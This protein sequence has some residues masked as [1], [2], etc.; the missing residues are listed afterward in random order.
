MQFCYMSK[1]DCINCVSDNNGINL[2]HFL[3]EKSHLHHYQAFT[4][5]CVS[6]SCNSL[7][8]LCIAFQISIPQPSHH[9]TVREEEQYVFIDSV[10]K[11]SDLDT[12]YHHLSMHN[13]GWFFPPSFVD[14]SS[15][16]SKVF[17]IISGLIPCGDETPPCPT[18]GD[19][20]EFQADSSRAFGWRYRCV[21]SKSAKS[22]KSKNRR[23]HGSVAAT[24]NTWFD[25]SNAIVDGMSCF[26][27]HFT[28]KSTHLL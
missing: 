20:T 22:R 10:Y 25:D 2:H 12:E 28:Y 6:A 11:F 15:I 27:R 8:S 26:F 5:Q 17:A 18:C 16:S 3:A 14:K 7:S 19:A 9:V 4:G 23:C 13:W 1:N 24:K 21:R